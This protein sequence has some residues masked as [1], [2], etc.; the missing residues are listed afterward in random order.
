[1]CNH[2]SL[3]RFRCGDSARLLADETRMRGGPWIDLAVTSPP[4]PLVSMWDD[5]FTAGDPAVAG[6]LD[7]GN[8]DEAF[9]LMHG[10]L[11]RVW[12]PLTAALKP[13]AHVCINIGDAVRSFG[14]DFRLWPNHLRIA[15]ACT[16][17]GL[18]MH[19]LILWRKTTNAP[20]KFMGSGM[21]PGKAYV[22]L[23]HEYILVFRK[24]GSR[25]GDRSLRRRSAYFWE[26]RNTWFSD[27]WVMK[28]ARQK[29]SRGDTRQ[30]S[31]AFPVELP[32]RLITMFSLQGDLVVDP[33]AG[34]G[35]TA[36]AALACG[37]NSLCLEQDAVLSG[38]SASRICEDE[39]ELAEWGMN[40]LK[41]HDAFVTRRL[42]AGKT[43][44]YR[45]AH[46]GFPVVT[47]QETDIRIP[48]MT[49]LGIG[50]DGVEAE[51][52]W[53]GPIV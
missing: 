27:T 18:F 20:T 10:Q 30:R 4:Y 39:A 46:Y 7:A 14:G 35:T 19:P 11:D 9:S 21:L 43:F 44:R 24:P 31:A 51:Y 37:R 49:S 29:L 45:N 2:S 33:F 26:E 6:A 1:V 47:A 3:A 52:T 16:R 12:E 5:D 36:K 50:S 48:C 53:G 17:L 22:T 34:T 32:S 15:D 40:R 13:G 41:T 23:E 25:V 42:G 38:A 28:A 8:P